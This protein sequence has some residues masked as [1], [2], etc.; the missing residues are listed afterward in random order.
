MKEVLGP[1]GHGCYCCN[2]AEQRR[3]REEADKDTAGFMV[4]LVGFT[5]LLMTLTPYVVYALGLPTMWG[6]CGWAWDYPCDVAGSRYILVGCG[7]VSVAIMALGFFMTWHRQREK[8]RLRAAASGG[9][10][11]GPEEE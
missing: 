2:R 11:D 10:V 3:I 6:G 4:A 5:L 1:Q 7:V 8:R 9:G